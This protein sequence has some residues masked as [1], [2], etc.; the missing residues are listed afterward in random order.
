VKLLS[1]V[2]TSH[3]L[4]EQETDERISQLEVELKVCSLAL[5]S[6]LTH[7]S[8]S[9]S[10]LCLSLSVSLSL[11]LS[12]SNLAQSAKAAASLLVTPKKSS[13]GG[14]PK[15]ARSSPLDYSTGTA[16]ANSLTETTA[17]LHSDL[18]KEVRPSASLFVSLS[19]P[20]PPLATS[21]S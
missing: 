4:R 7:L 11:S 15:F 9:L 12:L 1:E 5:A 18:R 3:T 20:H 19:N 17:K 6:R 10:S 14:G 13:N 2:I 16:A 21:I 8:V